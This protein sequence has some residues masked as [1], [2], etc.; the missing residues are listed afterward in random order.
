MRDAE[1]TAG[2]VEP[3]AARARH[4][5]KRRNAQQEKRC[6]AGLVTVDVAGV[7]HENFGAVVDFRCGRSTKV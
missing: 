2:G 4:S 1:H 5:G 3:A 6:L 7:S